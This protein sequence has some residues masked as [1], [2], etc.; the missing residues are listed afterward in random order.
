MKPLFKRPTFSV[1]MT[2]SPNTSSIPNRLSRHAAALTGSMNVA[3][4]QASDAMR[5][6]DGAK[7]A[8]ATPCY[9][10]AHD[11]RKAGDFIRSYLTVSSLYRVGSVKGLNAGDRRLRKAIDGA[12]RGY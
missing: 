4:K 2:Q 12:V 8:D 5:S 10:R 6:G 9:A 11:A 3:V 7:A 1:A